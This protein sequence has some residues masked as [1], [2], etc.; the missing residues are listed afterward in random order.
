MKSLVFAVF[1]ASVLAAPVMSYAQSDST[2]TRA[3]VRD[4]L[5]QLEQAG[6]NP[7]VGDD[8]NYPA[9]IQAAEARV[10]NQNGATAYG[11]VTS[12]ST[13]AGG[14]ATPQPAS[15]DQ[16]RKLYSGGQ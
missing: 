13:A 16:M 3:Q 9:D 2:I 1:A 12:G 6:Y 4:E 15:L 7:A 10:A 8:P 11:G 14:A 5:K